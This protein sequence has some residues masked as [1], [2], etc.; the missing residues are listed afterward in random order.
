VALVLLEWA[1]CQIGNASRRTHGRAPTGKADR[2]T[3]PAQAFTQW[4]LPEF[5]LRAAILR[6]RIAQALEFKPK[7]VCSA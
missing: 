7:E 4:V 3:A 6:Q 5:D 1:W 2:W